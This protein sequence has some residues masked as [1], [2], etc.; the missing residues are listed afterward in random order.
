MLMRY[1]YEEKVLP[2]PAA[3]MLFSVRMPSRLSFSLLNIMQP[4]VDMGTLL[5][6]SYAAC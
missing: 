3:M 2:L 1:L 4:W 6:Q 5:Y